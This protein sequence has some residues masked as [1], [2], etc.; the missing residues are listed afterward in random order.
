MDS[1]KEDKENI[2]DIEENFRVPTE[3]NI[4]I[5]NK[6][7]EL[8]LIYPEWSNTRLMSKSAD[9]WSIEKKMFELKEIHPFWSKEKLYNEAEK[10]WIN[11]KRD[12]IIE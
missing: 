7:N 9:L 5:H 12:I 8:K 3:Y 10:L 2:K 4:F 6:M 11:S 1:N